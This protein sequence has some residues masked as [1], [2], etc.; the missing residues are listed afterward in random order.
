MGPRKS[1]I[2]PAKESALIKVKQQ[3]APSFSQPITAN[4]SPG[5]ILAFSLKSFGSTI[6][7]RSSMLIKDS[8]LQQLDPFPLP[9]KQLI[10]SFL[11]MAL[12]PSRY[13]PSQAAEILF[14]ASCFHLSDKSDYTDKFNNS[15][16]VCQDLFL[17]A[18]KFP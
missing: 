16:N 9:L 7:P 10:F 2:P 1:R 6:C 3:V 4:L 12:P 13:L 11:F 15:D 17:L 14:P 18:G 8:T 5:L